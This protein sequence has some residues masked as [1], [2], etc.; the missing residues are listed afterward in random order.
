MPSSSSSAAAAARQP[1]QQR[2][3]RSSPQ[4]T[5]DEESRLSPAGDRVGLRSLARG[6]RSPSA[7]AP[8]ARQRLCMSTGEQ[9]QAAA[10]AASSTAVH[11][12]QQ[13]QEQ[14]L[15]LRQQ[16]DQQRRLRGRGAAS[17]A[18]GGGRGARWT[19]DE[20]SRLR[21]IVDELGATRLRAKKRRSPRASAPA[22]R[23]RPSRSTGK[24]CKRSGYSSSSSSAA[25][26]AAHCRRSAQSETIRIPAGAKPGQELRVSLASGKVVF[27]RV[28]PN[29]APGHLLKVVN[30]PPPASAAP[31]PVATP[32]DMAAL[33]A[34]VIGRRGGGGRAGGRRR[35]ADR[36]ADSRASCAA[37]AATCVAAGAAVGGRAGAAAVGSSAGARAAPGGQYGLRAAAPQP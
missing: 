21:Q 18:A 12:Q 22:A 20:E 29:V 23:Q 3:R 25:A 24:P 36:A 28:P 1:Q 27:V 7:S 6:R 19:A 32:A 34:G 11:Q 5:A 26:A 4:W 8:A 15:L 17:A 14:Q 31:L 37:G 16:Q 9:Q 30:G 10:A 35:E 2:R 33:S 13:Q